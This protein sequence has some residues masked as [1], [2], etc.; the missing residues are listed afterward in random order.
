MEGMVLE[1]LNNW[2]SIKFEIQIVQI[3]QFNYP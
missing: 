2:L 1:E 3:E